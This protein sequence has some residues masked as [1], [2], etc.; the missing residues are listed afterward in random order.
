MEESETG[1]KKR[2]HDPPEQ[3]TL[4]QRLVMKAP[5]QSERQRRSTNK[6]SSRTEVRHHLRRHTGAV[7]R[8]TLARHARR[9]RTAT[10]RHSQSRAHGPARRSRCIP[11][12]R[13]IGRK[14]LHYVLVRRALSIRSQRTVILSGSTSATSKIFNGNMTQ[15]T[16]RNTNT[17]QLRTLRRYD[18]RRRCTPVPEQVHQCLANGLDVRR[19]DT[20]RRGRQP[21]LRDE[22]PDL[23]RVERHVLVHLVHA[24]VT[25]IGR[26][27]CGSNLRAAEQRAEEFVQ[28]GQ[29]VAVRSNE[30][31]H[32]TLAHNA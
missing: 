18:R 30:R 26:E 9:R 4:S 14:R 5:S 19:G 6:R 24:L 25:S 17:V 32:R 20:E 21:D 3:P 13:R 2:L 27:V 12:H 8:S 22:V 31:Q 1:V 11:A 16:Y 23:D 15:T 7:H 10:D 29:E 28:M